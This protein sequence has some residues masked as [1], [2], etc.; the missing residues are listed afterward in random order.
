M[1]QCQDSSNDKIEQNAQIPTKENESI[2]RNIKISKETQNPTINNKGI[3]Q[4]GQEPKIRKEEIEIEK[5]KLQAS[6]EMMVPT[7]E[8]LGYSIPIDWK[9]TESTSTNPK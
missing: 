4:I 2:L 9:E 8:T 3:Y 5:N 6:Q 7:Q 1:G